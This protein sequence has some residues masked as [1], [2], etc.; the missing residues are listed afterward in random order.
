MKIFWSILVLLAIALG[1]ALVMPGKRETSPSITDTNGEII[2]KEHESEIPPRVPTPATSTTDAPKAV[3]KPSPATPAID[4]RSSEDVVFAKP[5]TDNTTQAPTILVKPDPVPTTPAAPP[6]TSD[7]GIPTGKE[8]SAKPDAPAKPFTIIDSKFEKK[9]DGSL[10][11]DDRFVI[12][13]DGTKEKPYEITWELLTSAE[14]LYN[15]REGKRQMPSAVAMLDGKHVTITGYVAFPL[16]V[17]DPKEYIV[18]LNQWDGCC[19]GVPPTPF[20]AIEVQTNTAVKGDDRF[21]VSGTVS[22]ILGV[23]PYTVGDWLVG[24]YIMDDAA[25]KPGEFGNF[26]GS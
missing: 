13:G 23:K 10:L 3:T 25:L 1:V 7:P 22:G 17:Q 14:K 24:L 20:D 18:M 6:L 2:A 19:I 15:P 26:G 5:T 16:Y 4:N 21:A 11:V 9:P 12:K 8:N